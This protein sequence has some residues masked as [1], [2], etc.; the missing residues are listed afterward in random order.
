MVGLLLDLKPTIIKKRQMEMN[1][2]QNQKVPISVERGIQ[3]NP[4]KRNKFQID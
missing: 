2:L 4:I 1:I 3:E